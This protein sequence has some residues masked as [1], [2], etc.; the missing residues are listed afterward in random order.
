MSGEPSGER[1]RGAGSGEGAAEEGVGNGFER[2]GAGCG[3][4]IQAAVESGGGVVVG[5]TLCSGGV[6]SKGGACNTLCSGEVR[7]G[8]TSSCGGEEG[9]GGEK[10]FM[11]SCNWAVR[12]SGEDGW[13]ACRSWGAILDRAMRAAVRSLMAARAVSCGVH[14]GMVTRW[15]SQARVSVTR[16]E[17]VAVAQTV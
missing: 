7:G 17:D 1:L 2:G 15:G 11:K 12:V 4:V 13:R 3:E 14:E 9:D 6:A 5:D 8:V 10:R 16:T